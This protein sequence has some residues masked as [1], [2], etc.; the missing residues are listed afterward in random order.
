MNKF[1]KLL[2]G[3]AALIKNPYLLN[4]VIEDDQVWYDY[5]KTKENRAL[6]IV[7]LLEII[8]KLNEELNHT[9][10]LGGGSMV[11][12][13]ALLRSLARKFE[14]TRYFEIGTWRGESVAQV[15]DLCQTCYTLNLSETEMKELGLNE[16]YAQLHGVLSMKNPKIVHLEGNSLHYNFAGLNQKFDLVFIDGDHHYDAVKSDT[17]NVVQHLIH[18]NSIVVWHDAAYHGEKQR[19]EVIAGILD[20]LPEELHPHVYHV[21]NTMCAVMIK[22]EFKKQVLDAPLRPENLFKVR[23]RNT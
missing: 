11:T 15:A 23:I 3:I 12:D 22:G 20:G 5:L 16:K 17:Q 14:N 13:M 18:E 9:T 1:T 4:K 6:H 7:D 10:F 19:P 8:P 21:S 2:K